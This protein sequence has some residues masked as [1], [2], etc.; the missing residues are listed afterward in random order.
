MGRFDDYLQSMDRVPDVKNP[1]LPS[2]TFMRHWDQEKFEES[3]E[4]IHTVRLQIDEAVLETT[5]R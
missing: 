3:K 4:K 5:P 2:E 1:A